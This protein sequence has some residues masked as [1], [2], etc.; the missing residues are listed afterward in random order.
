MQYVAKIYIDNALL[1]IHLP[2]NVFLKKEYYID[3]VVKFIHM[4][5]PQYLEKWLLKS[6][7]SAIQKLKGI[8]IHTHTYRLAQ[9]ISYLLQS[10]SKK[11]LVG[12]CRKFYT[13]KKLPT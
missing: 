1:A 13:K 8:S 12:I 11:I 5:N 7:E 2:K 6:R 9:N 4:K 10:S 3:L